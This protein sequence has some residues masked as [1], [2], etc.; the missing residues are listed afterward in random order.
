M[1]K[2][3]LEH[4]MIQV[5][6]EDRKALKELSVKLGMKIPDTMAL[7]MKYVKDKNVDL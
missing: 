6:K 7:I 1:E 4:T 2:Q 5:Y 3:V